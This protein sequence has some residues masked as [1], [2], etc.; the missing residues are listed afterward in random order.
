MNYTVI[1][2]SR[3]NHGHQ[4]KDWLGGY[5]AGKALGLNYFHTEYDYLDYFIPKSY[6]NSIQ[7]L[8]NNEEVHVRGHE[9]S[10]HMDGFDEY[11]DFNNFMS[12]FN[13]KKLSENNLVVFS[14]AFRLHPFQ[15]IPWFKNGDISR[16][17]FLE[18]CKELED[19][20]YIDKEKKTSDEK[21]IVAIHANFYRNDGGDSF[22]PRFRF[23]LEYYTNII[24]QISESISNKKVEFHIY[25]EKA[26]SHEISNEFKNKDQCFVHV[27]SNRQKRNYEQINH[28]FKDFVD[29]DILVCSNSSFSVVASYYRNSKNK[30]TIYH[31]HLH[32]NHLPEYNYIAADVN[33]VLSSH[34][35]L[36]IF[37]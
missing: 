30:V 34:S 37:N 19:A 17:L 36:K 12:K 13:E 32:L 6:F 7:N 18:T 22:R 33:G 5:V 10:G 20:F 24:S 4:I 16:D 29:A 35:S 23:G 25:T 21:I 9:P 28:I 8:K 27:G 1:N 11:N 31:P 15:T 3:G 26:G 2:K 14:N